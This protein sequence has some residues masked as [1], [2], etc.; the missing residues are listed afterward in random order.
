MGER[1]EVTQGKPMGRVLRDVVALD[2]DRVAL[3]IGGE[4][5]S[6]GELDRAISNAAAGLQAAGVGRGWRIPLV[7]DTS[8]LAVAALIGATHVG[9]ATA[10]MNPRLTSGELAVL[11]EAAGTAA[12]GVVG[13]RYAAV[14]AAA[15]I[16]PVLGVELLDGSPGA[17]GAGAAGVQESPEPAGDAVVLFTSGTTG[18]PKAVPLTHEQVAP[19]I[20]AFA[21]AVEPVPSVSIMSVPLVHIGGM[22]GLLVALAKGSTTVVLTR[23]DAGEWLASVERHRVTTA[24]LVPTMLY[25]ILE[26]PD[27]SRTDLSSLASLSYG[28]APATPELIRRTM[29]A[30]PGVDLMNTFGQ[31]ETMGSITALGPGDHPPERLASVGRPLPGVEIR[32]VHPTT[33]EDVETGTA[34]ELWVRSDVAVVIQPDAGDGA[35]PAGWFRTGDMVSADA[36]GYL[37]PSGR[38]SDTINRGGE[39]FS[40]SEVEEVV[41]AHPV[42]RDVAAVGVVDPEMGHRVGVAVVIGEPL[43]LD[44]LRAFCQGRIANFKLPEQLLVVDELPITDFGKVD[45]KDLRTRFAEAGES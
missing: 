10:L 4:P 7:D 43:D 6:Y 39:K 30:L 40:P 33:G 22:L 26:H 27:F 45:R 20:A 36:E 18:T 17:A 13:A 11:M 25:R 37:F 15:G 28:A 29:D 38:L 14:A 21:P 44:E 8:V 24:F 12:T 35:T 31:T 16:D 19:R 1:A 23:F 32:I 5:T 9:A 2:P 41:R 34:G 3:I 42:V